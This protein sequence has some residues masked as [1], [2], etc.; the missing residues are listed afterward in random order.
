MANTL[1][2]SNENYDNDSLWIIMINGSSLNALN[3]SKTASVLFVVGVFGIFTGNCEYN[4]K[5]VVN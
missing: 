2:I 5:F 1:S 3:L 4:R